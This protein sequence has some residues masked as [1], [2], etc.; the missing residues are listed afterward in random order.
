[1]TPNCREYDMLGFQHGKTSRNCNVATWYNCNV[2]EC[3]LGNGPCSKQ[4]RIV[5]DDEDDDDGHSASLRDPSSSFTRDLNVPT[6]AA[7]ESLAERALRPRQVLQESSSEWHRMWILPPY[8]ERI[9]KS[10]S[11]MIHR[12]IWFLNSHAPA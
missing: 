6:S 7:N 3:Y 5:V 2:A 11:I 12:G 10:R 8:L 1:M 4:P 9:A